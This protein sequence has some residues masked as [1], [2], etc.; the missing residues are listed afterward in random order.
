[1]TR[2]YNSRMSVLGAGGIAQ[3]V[4]CCVEYKK[5]RLDPWHHVK[6]GIGHTPVIPALGTV[7]PQ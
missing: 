4:E 5:T 6:V 3:F 7:V 2:L 1:M